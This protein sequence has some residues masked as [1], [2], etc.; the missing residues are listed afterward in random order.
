M[1]NNALDPVNQ[2]ERAL[3]TVLQRLPGLAPAAVENG[4]GGGHARGW[5]CILAS[6]DADE[7]ADRGSGVA[8][9]ARANFNKAL[10]HALMRRQQVVTPEPIVLQCARLLIWSR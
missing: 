7:N 10:G 8:A 4:I 9:R 2:F 6:H 5:R 3:T 1:H